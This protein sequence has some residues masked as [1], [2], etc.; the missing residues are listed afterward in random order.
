MSHST[1]DLSRQP[2][3]PPS[4]AV[5]YWILCYLEYWIE[6]LR[7]HY[8][9]HFTMKGTTEPKSSFLNEAQHSMFPPRSTHWKGIYF[10]LS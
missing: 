8:N 7:Q 2:P 3:Y 5:L 6:D 10:G 1:L 4:N 9:H